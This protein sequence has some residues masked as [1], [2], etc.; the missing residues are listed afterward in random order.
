MSLTACNDETED[1]IFNLSRDV[2][3]DVSVKIDRNP[4]NHRRFFAFIKIAF[5]NQDFFQNQEEF[6]KWVT[7]KAGYY[8]TIKSPNGNVFYQAQSL[9]FGK[10]DEIK[11]R[12]VFNHAITAYLSEFDQ[13]TRDQICEIAEFI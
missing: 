10:M 6:R 3:I 2:E 9:S 5:E 12:E 4:S 8:D 13:L 7:C 11:F 1:F